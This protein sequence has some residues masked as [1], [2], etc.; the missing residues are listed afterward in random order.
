M[1]SLAEKLSVTELHKKRMREE[2]IAKEKPKRRR[3]GSVFKEHE[4]SRARVCELRA[5]PR[6]TTVS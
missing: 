2:E 3:R 5:T 6:C 1:I 4:E